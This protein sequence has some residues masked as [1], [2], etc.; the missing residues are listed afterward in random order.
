MLSSL[1]LASTLKEWPSLEQHGSSFNRLHTGVPA[2]TNGVWPPLQPVSV[3]QKNKQLTLL[4]S[5]VQSIGL[6]IDCT[7]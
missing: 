4:A 6:H 3:V 5:Y 2:C 7:A 1:M